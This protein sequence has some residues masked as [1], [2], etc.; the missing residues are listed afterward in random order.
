MNKKFCTS[1][2]VCNRNITQHFI[3]CRMQPTSD[4]DGSLKQEQRAAS[5]LLRVLLLLVALQVRL[6]VRAR[7]LVRRRVGR[8]ALARSRLT[9]RRRLLS[10]R[11][12]NFQSFVKLCGPG[13][14]DWQEILISCLLLKEGC[15][16]PVSVTAGVA[17]SV[18]ISVP[19]T[20]VPSPPSKPFNS[21]FFFAVS[22]KKN[23][24]ELLFSQFP[25]TS[26][27]KH[28]TLPL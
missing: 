17:S 19:A 15:T 12:Q 2:G 23:S 26:K 16:L 7:L 5:H 14:Q 27:P 21:F 24:N 10:L 20:A 3:L 18:P 6:A 28:Q 22:E 11:R 4:A 13:R 25:A 1:I 9:R 8:L